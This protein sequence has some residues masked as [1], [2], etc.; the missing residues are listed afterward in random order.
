[1]NQDVQS[2]AYICDRLGPYHLARLI[3]LNR[4]TR[5]SAL[6]LSRLDTTYQ[7]DEVRGGEFRRLTLFAEGPWNDHPAGE[8][9]SKVRR[10]LDEIAPEVVAIP[11]WECPAAL[12]ALGWCLEKGVPSVLMADSQYHD[13]ERQRW[14]EALKKRIVTL[15]D[16]GFVGGQ[17]HADYLVRLGMAG[18]RIFTGYNVV[19]ND[20]FARAAG[21]I[22]ANVSFMRSALKLPARYFLTS[23]RLQEK[24][25]LSVLLQAYALCRRQLG[26]E[27]WGLVVVG[28]GPL[29]PQLEKLADELGIADLVVFAGFKQYGELPAYYTLASAFVLPSTVE[30]WG[31]VVN[32]AMACGLPV[33]VSEVCGCAGSLVLSGVNGFTFHPRDVQGLAALMR[34][35]ARECDLEEMGRASSE[36]IAGFTPQTFADGLLRAARTARSLPRRRASLLDRALLSLVANR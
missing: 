26:E 4:L 23:C 6:E 13:L 20:H 18:D 28:D 8:V 10:A 16:V 3:A 11:G 5:V 32:E 22:R 19:D 36:I 12:G 25:N 2:I 34:R 29:R 15:H 7:W 30:Q 1:M 33:L 35:L 31:L 14:K 17:S 21:A 27:G 24:K 9:I